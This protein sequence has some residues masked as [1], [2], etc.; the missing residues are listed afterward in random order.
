[1]SHTYKNCVRF[2]AFISITFKQLYT[3]ISSGQ[4]QGVC[5]W[6]KAKDTWSEPYIRDMDKRSRNK[7]FVDFLRPSGWIS[8][9]L[10]CILVLYFYYNLNYQQW[11]ATESHVME[12][13]DIGLHFISIN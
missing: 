12:G 1:M 11:K 2:Q 3:D 13:H 6:L 10:L 5:H 7:S 4:N 9:C 8:R